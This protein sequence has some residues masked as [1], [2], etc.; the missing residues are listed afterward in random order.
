MGGSFRAD[1]FRSESPPDATKEV[2]WRPTMSQ[3]FHLPKRFH[4]PNKSRTN[5][6][7]KRSFAT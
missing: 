7:Q 1:F 4:V 2:M 3:T 6:G 5:P